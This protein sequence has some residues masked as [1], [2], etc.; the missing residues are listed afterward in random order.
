[1]YRIADAMYGI[2]TGEA[3]QDREECHKLLIL[4]KEKRE[5]LCFKALLEEGL[6]FSIP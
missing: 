3:M 1:M 5:P 4:L 6:Q 2:E